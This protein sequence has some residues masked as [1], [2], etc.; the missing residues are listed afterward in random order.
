MI[1]GQIA[2]VQRRSTR[3]VARIIKGM[4]GLKPRFLY[5]W[6]RRIRLNERRKGGDRRGGLSQFK[7]AASRPKTGSFGVRVFGMR[8]RKLRP[9][10]NGLGNV[11]ETVQRGALLK[12]RFRQIARVAI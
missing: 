3:G 7:I 6:T 11:F 1:R 8:C 12:A 5:I 2:G 9:R 4:S 10:F